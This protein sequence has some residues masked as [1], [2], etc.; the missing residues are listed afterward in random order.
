MAVHDNTATDAF[1]NCIVSL[2]LVI[3]RGNYMINNKYRYSPGEKQRRQVFHHIVD[4]ISTNYITVEKRIKELYPER[5]KKTT[6]ES[7]L[8][9][10]S[11]VYDFLTDLYDNT[12][13]LLESEAY[14]Y[15]TIPEIKKRIKKFFH[16]KEIDAPNRLI[17]Y[18]RNKLVYY[19]SVTIRSYDNVDSISNKDYE[20]VQLLEIS[21][22]FSDIDKKNFKCLPIKKLFW[23]NSFKLFAIALLI[24]KKI[25]YNFDQAKK[26]PKHYNL[27]ITLEYELLNDFN[28]KDNNNNWDDDYI[29]DV[30]DI[31]TTLHWLDFLTS[32]NLIKKT[33]EDN[34]FL[35]FLPEMFLDSKIQNTKC[36]LNKYKNQ[37][38]DKI[39]K[40]REKEKSYNEAVKTLLATLDKKF[41]RVCK[42]KK[43]E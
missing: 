17:K 9:P 33:I 2:Y 21:K 29:S 22:C 16:K 18:L 35:A 38:I 32:K 5:P 23:R 10:P 27:E 43:G 8:P 12:I 42:I 19:A 11:V 1:D 4:N 41:Y 28:S 39:M 7:E 37:R 31:D 40:T 15:R 6:M 36:I 3:I 25:I 20:K 34:N 30:T 13:S 26:E 24:P 14:R